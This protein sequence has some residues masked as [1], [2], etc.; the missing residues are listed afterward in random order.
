MSGLLTV[1]NTAP[2]AFLS[3]EFR[4]LGWLKISDMDDKERMFQV[5]TQEHTG[6]LIRAGVAVGERAEQPE[7]HPAA[8]LRRL[9][10]SRGWWGPVC[11][12]S[13]QLCL[14]DTEGG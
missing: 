5:G 8:S 13:P 4:H 1:C 11:A 12:A 6:S 3:H 2:L 10:P 9:C 7:T 14:R